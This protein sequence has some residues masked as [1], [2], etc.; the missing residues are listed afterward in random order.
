MEVC[1]GYLRSREEGQTHSAPPYPAVGW[2]A[3]SA[4]WKEAGLGLELRSRG[5]AR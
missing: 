1:L 3:A 4:S 5:E 2:G